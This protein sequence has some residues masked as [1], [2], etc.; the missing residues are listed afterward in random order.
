MKLRL[1]STRGTR[2]FLFSST[3][4][5]PALSSA[6]TLRFLLRSRLPH[7]IGSSRFGG[8]CTATGGCSG[9]VVGESI[10]HDDV[11]VSFVGKRHFSFLAHPPLSLTPVFLL[12][13]RLPSRS[14]QHVTATSAFTKPKGASSSRCRSIDIPRASLHPS[15]NFP[16]FKSHS[17]AHARNPFKLTR[18]YLRDGRQK[19]S[20]EVL[21]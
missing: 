5:F 8:H 1:F 11:V 9:V 7:A 2:V 4:R 10:F 15:S 21:A 19:R 3:L 6:T 12:W 20:P 16:P 18:R 17:A 14:A 13:L